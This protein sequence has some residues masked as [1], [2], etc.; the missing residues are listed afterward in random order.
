MA[1]EQQQSELEISAGFRRGERWAFE[2][3]AKQYFFHIANFISQL[4]Q[5]RDRGMEL[6]Q[7]SFFLACR[8]H[9]QVDPSRSLAPWLFQIARNLAYKESKRR[10]KQNHISL[11]D[12][13]PEGEIPE[14]KVEV[15]PRQTTVKAEIS[16]RIQRALER[17]KPSNRDILTL[18]MIQGLP[19]ETV[20][21]M[22]K[23]PIATVNTRIHRALKKLRRLARQE[24]LR[25]DEVF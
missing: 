5:D 12:L 10:K 15:N 6:A 21:E 9:K 19:S 13:D 24:G 7:E 11:H 22:L 3:A 8:A 20:A 25:E 4:L 1:A 18:R 16:V 23:I 17:L 14:L 2:A